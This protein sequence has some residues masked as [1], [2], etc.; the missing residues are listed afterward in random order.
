MRRMRVDVQRVVD[1][2][3][4][5]VYALLSD[6]RDGHLRI[7][8]GA[9]FRDVALEAGGSGAGTILRYRSVAGR[10]ER[11]YRMLVSEPEP[12]RVL[13][14]SSTTSSLVTTFTVSPVDGGK[15]SRVQI[16]T[17]IDAYPGLLGLAQRALCPSAMRGI[18][19]KELRLLATVMRQTTD[20]RPQ[21]MRKL[22]T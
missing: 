18:Y 11:R 3:P 10:G 20:D 19:R 17:E 4:E 22:Q 1:A 13:R 9:N 14:E 7:L 8:P 16:S 2:T 12:G 5:K 21:T 15:R 6:Y